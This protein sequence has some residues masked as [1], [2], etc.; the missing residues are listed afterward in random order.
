MG[1]I[2]TRWMVALIEDGWNVAEAKEGAECDGRKY[3]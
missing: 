3:L 1:D 2:V